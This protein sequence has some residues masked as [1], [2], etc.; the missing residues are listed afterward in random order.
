VDTFREAIRDTF[1]G[2]RQ[3][4][5]TLD[6]AHDK[7]FALARPGYKVEQVDAFFDEA[8]REAGGDAADLQGT[9]RLRRP[10]RLSGR[11]H[12]VGS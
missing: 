2:V 9:T 12:A 6:E 4:P 10:I 7:R 1:L 3:P 8:E 5:L 11:F